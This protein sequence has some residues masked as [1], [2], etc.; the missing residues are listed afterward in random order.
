MVVSV[1]CGE[2]GTLNCRRMTGSSDFRLFSTDIQTMY[3]H[4]VAQHWFESLSGPVIR[5]IRLAVGDTG[6]SWSDRLLRVAVGFRGTY[7]GC[8]VQDLMPQP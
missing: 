1:A 6:G 2:V 7:S 8:N 4:R 5:H 3:I